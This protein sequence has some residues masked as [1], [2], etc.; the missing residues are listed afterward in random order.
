[1]ART[2]KFVGRS[3]AALREE[4]EENVVLEA[5]SCS[6][7]TV[8]KNIECRERREGESSLA[9]ERIEDELLERFSGPFLI[10]GRTE[11]HISLLD[12]F[13]IC[14]RQSNARVAISEHWRIVF[15]VSHG[16]YVLRPHLGVSEHY[17]QAPLFGE[18]L[19]YNLKL[20]AIGS[21][22]PDR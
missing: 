22:P 15:T 7:A 4:R 18:A 13:R 19:W 6:C 12:G 16:G 20:H 9:L 10:V 14:V 2:P 11:N 8:E 3:R 21:E 1:M 17:L 5:S